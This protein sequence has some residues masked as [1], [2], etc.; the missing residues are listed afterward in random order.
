MKVYHRYQATNY[1]CGA[2][3]FSMLF[4]QMSEEEARKRCKTTSSGTYMTNVKIALRDLG[5]E[6]HFIPMNMDYTEAFKWLEGVAAHYPVLISG[7][8]RDRFCNKG[9][10]RVRHHMVAAQN[11]LVFDPSER[12]P[13]P[14]DAYEIVFNKGLRISQVLIVESENEVYGRRKVLA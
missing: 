9:R 13:L 2:A 8:F 12:H 5:I 3:C 1:S 6:S 7:E 4:P 11:G 14:F 10:D